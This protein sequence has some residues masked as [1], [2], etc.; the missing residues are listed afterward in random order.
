MSMHRFN[1]T[2]I[3]VT[4]AAAGIGRA[5]TLHLIAEGARVIAA[6]RS[7]DQLDGLVAEVN[8]ERLVPVVGDITEQTVIDRIV[9]AGAGHIDGVA[10]VA[11]ITDGWLPPH[12][13]TDETWLKVFELN[14][15]ANMRLTRA[16][17]PAM[18]ER[19]QGNFVFVS[20]EASFRASLSG[21]AYT[22]SKLALNGFARSVAFYY[23]ARGIRSNVVAPAGVSTAMDTQIH[24]EYAREAIQ[25]ILAT[26]PPRVEPDV[27]AR[28]ILWLLSDDSPTVNG[29]VLPCDSGWT[30]V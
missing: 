3:I 14:V 25:P 29:V 12:E 22:S 30:T 7:A 11:G 18:L 8:S 2:T 13:M 10:A 26:A 5:T 9:A 15:T 27:V 28:S 23:G 19:G 16:V 4:G 20:S 17:L 24:S 6:D 1:D 21:A